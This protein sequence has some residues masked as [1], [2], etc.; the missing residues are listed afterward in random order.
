MDWNDS[1]EKTANNKMKIKADKITFRN[2]F[3]IETK[4][5]FDKLISMKR[6]SIKALKVEQRV[7]NNALLKIQ[8]EQCYGKLTEYQFATYKEEGKKKIFVVRI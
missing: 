3:R 4:E 1:S 7:I 5:V 8:R 2:T 6:K